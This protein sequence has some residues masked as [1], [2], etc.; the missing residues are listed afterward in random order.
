MTAMKPQAYVP[1]G[2]QPLLRELPKGGEYPIAALGPLREAVEAAQ[3]TT[4]APMAL[5]AQSALSV[6]SLAVQ[7]H[8]N[9][10]TLGGD[11]PVS[12]YCLTI[13]KSGERKSATDRLLM[14]GLRDH[15]AEANAQHREDV[16][17]WENAVELHKAERS[18]IMG[19]FKGAKGKGK[20]SAQNDL[21][22][23]GPE[24]RAPI[25]P[26]LTATEPTLEGLHKL[27]L[28][29]QPSLGLFSDEG[30]GFLGGH[31]MSQ[32]HRLKTVAGL[33]ALWGG[34]PLT[35]V[36]AGDG[37]STLFGRRLAAHLMV[38]PVAARPL[39]ADPVA[40]GQGFLARFLIAE[41]ESAIGFRLLK[42]PPADA[43]QSLDSFAL[44][45][46]SILTASKPVD[47][48]APQE[49]KPPCL[50][51]SEAARDALWT[52]HLEI[53]PEQ[54]PGGP[55][56]A[57]TAYASK[58]VEQA[59]RIAGVLALW[60]NLRAV[61]VGEPMMRCGITLARFYLGEAKRLA[62]TAE[63]SAETDKAE[64]LRQWLL[65]NWPEIA[66]NNDREA[67]TILP[68][69]ITRFG[70]GS[71]REAKTVTALT[72]ILVRYGWLV[73][74]EHGVVIDGA[75]RK[76]AFQIVGAKNGF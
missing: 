32:D 38:Q 58:T 16:Q 9:V 52:Y 1:E 18:Q 5:A 65:D 47:D 3:A 27:F 13:A 49:L 41:P 44:K 57:L 61:E 42:R 2:P 66:A 62:E 35:R 19:E 59:A 20:A 11:A 31:G 8:G 17:A 50:S 67:H 68:R 73:P 30:G 34:D 63:V 53:E 10:E 51:L 29:G 7:A 74:L 23:L 54:R 55:L 12:L 15:E 75:A 33:S 60:D 72:S 24:P 46:R 26:N 4:Q 45:L 71:M 22:A 48:E 70:P 37:T 76:V 28:I 39:L 14:R 6:A 56:E 64:N 40:S 36:R 43:G 21:E 25:L 69:D